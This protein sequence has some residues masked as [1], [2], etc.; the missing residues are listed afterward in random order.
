MPTPICSKCRQVIPSDDINVAQDVAYCRQ[1]NISYRLSDLTSGNDASA[2]V[3][4][5]RPP[6]GAWYRSDGGGTVIGATNRSLGA[7]FFMVIFALGWNSIVSMFVVF[8]IAGTLHILHIPAPAWFPAPK[9]NGGDM[10]TGSVLFMWLFL[11]PFIA[12]GLMVLSIALSSLFG[13]TEVKIENTRGTL[14]TGV[15]PVGW[16]RQFDTTQVKNV[17]ISESYNRN[18]NNTAA[19]LLETREGK[20]FKLGSLLSNERR[21]FVLGAM[22][23][24]LVR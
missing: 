11:T 9:M 3:D 16:K 6:A 13:R 8:A 19:I 23:K 21:Q 14:F 5:N 18:G 24:A 15:G 20:Q 2:Y 22:Q 17:R 1:C 12:V 10:G 7:A 4:L